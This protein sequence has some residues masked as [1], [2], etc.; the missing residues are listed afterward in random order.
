[1]IVKNRHRNV[2]SFLVIASFL[3]LAVGS[4][5]TPEQ[6]KAREAKEV[7]V[8]ETLAL[9]M[10]TLATIDARVKTLDTASLNSV[11]CDAKAMLGKVT[12]EKRKR[13]LRLHV[14]YAP[15]LERFSS[16]DK[17]A[18]QEDKS[19]WAWVSDFTWKGHFERPMAERDAYS[20]NS[21]AETMR[22]MFV[23]NRYMIVVVPAS[24][25]ANRLPKIPKAGDFTSGEFHGWAVVFD[26][27]DA[28]VACQYRIDAENSN[29]VEFKTRGLMKEEPDKAILKDFQDNFEDALEK[30]LPKGISLGTGYG[31]ILK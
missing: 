8:K 13:G 3:A 24:K 4:S 6:K 31:K 9:Y 17:A 11:A 15:F 22:D 1:M 14:A 7:A 16:N 28:T 12:E 25:D 26:Q 19:P 20:I 10:K 2:L 23:A 21:T 18:W 29:S 27:T 5:E 30:G